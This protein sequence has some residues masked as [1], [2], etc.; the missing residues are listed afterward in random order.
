MDDQRYAAGLPNLLDADLSIDR[1]AH[2]QP[3]SQPLAT[4]IGAKTGLLAN[5]GCPDHST[6]QLVGWEDSDREPFPG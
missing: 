2:P 4:L 3:A 6:A 5:A 1:I